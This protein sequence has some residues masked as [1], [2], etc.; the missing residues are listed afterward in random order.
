LT[1][2][3]CVWDKGQPEM[4]LASDVIIKL[5]AHDAINEPNTISRTPKHIIVNSGWDYAAPKFNDD[6]AI[7]LMEEKVSSGSAFINTICIADI[8]CRIKNF[9]SLLSCVNSH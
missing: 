3:H 7:L 6:L 5:G 9:T 8:M 1:A 2:A 4:M